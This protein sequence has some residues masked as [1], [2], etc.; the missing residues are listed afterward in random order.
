MGSEHDRAERHRTLARA[1]GAEPHRHRAAPDH[2]RLWADPGVRS[3]ERHPQ[4]RLRA[5]RTQFERAVDPL[6][7]DG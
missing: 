7:D 4:D 1:P 6:A 5:L 3:A 2:R